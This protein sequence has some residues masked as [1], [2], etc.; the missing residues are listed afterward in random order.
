MTRIEK[1]KISLKAKRVSQVQFTAIAIFLVALLSLLF[2]YND[3]MVR[4]LAIT[5][6]ISI[7]TFLFL[8]PWSSDLDKK[9]SVYKKDLERKREGILL[10]IALG[11]LDEKPY[12]IEKIKEISIIIKQ[13][14]NS[15][16]LMGYYMA[17]SK[18]SDNEE[19]RKMGEYFQKAYFDKRK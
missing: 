17:T 10:K 3:F 2:I 9:L 13:P 5:M 8:A 4:I 16:V 7:V 14:T 19:A 11:Y 18:N 1:N 6:A 12:D 15:G